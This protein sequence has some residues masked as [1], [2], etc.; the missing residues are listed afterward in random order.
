[1]TE[2]LEITGELPA[3]APTPTTDVLGVVGELPFAGDEVLPGAVALPE[4]VSRFAIGTRPSLTDLPAPQPYVLAPNRMPPAQRILIPSIG[5]DSKVVHLGIKE[6]KGKWVWETPDHAVGHHDGTANPK[7]GSNTVLSGHMSSP[8]KGEG[9]IFKRLPEVKVGDR[10]Y[11]ETALGVLPYT[12]DEIKLVS[13]TELWVMFPTRSETL[14][15]I[16]CYPDLVY[17][18]RLVVT[19]KPVSV[20]AS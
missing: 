11:V 10:V 12:V 15:L 4:D 19:A 6:D 9:S 2:V 7:E 18:Y 14:T 5:V 17:T 1:M 20:E 8:V 16:T 13:P 3:P